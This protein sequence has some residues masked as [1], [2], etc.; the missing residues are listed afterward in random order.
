MA[1]ITPTSIT[2][3]SGRVQQVTLAEEVTVLGQLLIY[4]NGYKLGIASGTT[5][6]SVVYCMALELGIVD[7]SI[8]VLMPGGIVKFDAILTT[9]I[10]YYLSETLGRIS[11]GVLS[12]N[13]TTVVGVAEDT[14]NLLFSVINSRAVKA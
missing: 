4:D 1:D 12:G 2:V 10:P 9:A 11:D 14:Q 6:Q 7:A 5:V 3:V 8:R 13:H